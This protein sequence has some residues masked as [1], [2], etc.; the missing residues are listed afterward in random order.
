MSVPSSTKKPGGGFRK[1]QA[2]VYTLL[3]A[4]ALLAIIVGIVFLY[5]HMQVYEFKIKGG[6][7]VTMLVHLMPIAGFFSFQ[8][9]RKEKNKR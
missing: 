8:K 2:D 4:I 9:S 6:P 7:T 1:P 5:L 3:L